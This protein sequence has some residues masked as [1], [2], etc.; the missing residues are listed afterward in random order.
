MKKDTFLHEMKGCSIT[1]GD[2]TLPD[3]PTK[4]VNY[5]TDEEIK[6]KNVADAYENAVIDGKPLK[7][8]VDESTLDDL[9][10]FT[11][12]DRDLMFCDPDELMDPDEEE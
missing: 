8:I 7:Q 5:K 6:F 2:W 1:I 12:D 3:K 9:F 4:L 10:T 11:L